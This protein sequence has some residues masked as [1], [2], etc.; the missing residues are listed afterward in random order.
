MPCSGLVSDDDER[1]IESPPEGASCAEHPEREAFVICPRCGS[2]CCIAC[3]HNAVRRCHDCLVRE[4]GP[5]VPWEDRTRSLPGRFVATLA[6][7]F[8][9][10]RSAPSFATSSVGSALSFFTL[11]FVPIALASGIIPYTRTLLFGAG[12]VEIVGHPSTNEIAIDVARAAGLGLLIEALKV[13]CLA[14]P[15]HSLSR[16]YASR[17]HP[18]AALS[19]MLYR[20]WLVPAMPLLLYLFTWP[21]SADS[22]ASTSSAMISIASLLP[23]LVLLSSMLAT[24]RMASGVGPIAS[25]IVVLV[26]FV[27]MMVCVQLGMETIAPWLPDS[28]AIRQ[29]AGAG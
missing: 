4:P 20:G 3:W 10:T 2:F 29:A 16:A 15:Y 23:L 7:A 17:G 27:V 24:A 26:P 5:P 9:P 11:T 22:A 25:L 1:P 18:P 6:D 28:E 19:A 14:V 12:A 13:L 8:R 21:L